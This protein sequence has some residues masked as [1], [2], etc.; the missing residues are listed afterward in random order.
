MALAAVLL[1]T[2]CAALAP[3]QVVTGVVLEVNGSSLA[4][5][6][7]FILR[8]ADGRVMT[9]SLGALDPSGLRA[10]H[11][12]EHQQAAEPVRVT[13]QVQGARNV[14]TKLEDAS[15]SPSP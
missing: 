2:G 7:G 8:A 13:Y 10:Q 5:V 6:D 11:L 4:E 1:F 3:D 12:H 14:A 9:F 15:A